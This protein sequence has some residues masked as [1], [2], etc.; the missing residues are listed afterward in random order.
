VTFCTE[1][2]IE[3]TNDSDNCPN[4]SQNQPDDS[5]T[6]VE[7]PKPESKSGR[8]KTKIVLGLGVIISLSLI[9]FI[10]GAFGFY[11]IVA[12]QYPEL[13]GMNEFDDPSPSETITDNDVYDGD[14]D[15]YDEDLFEDSEP[16]EYPD[17]DLHLI[18]MDGPGEGAVTV[19]DNGSVTLDTKTGEI[20]I[21]E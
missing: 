14:P 17:G 9:F 18:D 21:D 8:S 2:G 15:G 12:A 4:C 16:V 3:L 7:T 19:V 11:L 13:F 5:L 10:M 1:C 20:E 6:H